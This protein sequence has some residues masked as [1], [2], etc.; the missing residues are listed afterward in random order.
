MNSGALH[1]QRL[2]RAGQLHVLITA[3]RCHGPVNAGKPILCGADGEVT[4]PNHL[5]QMRRII[6]QYLPIN[7]PRIID[8]GPLF[9]AALPHEYQPP[10]TV[11]FDRAV[12]AT[13]EHVFQCLRSCVAQLPAVT[14]ITAIAFTHQ[15][16]VAHLIVRSPI[17]APRHPAKNVECYQGSRPLRPV[18]MSSSAGLAAPYVREQGHLMIWPPEHRY[19]WTG[20]GCIG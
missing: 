9:G 5:A 14:E 19:R 18:G 17:L 13:T 7:L 16:H 11:R 12:M 20:G 6:E 15:S 3:K 10:V 1:S 8:T 2:A 4:A